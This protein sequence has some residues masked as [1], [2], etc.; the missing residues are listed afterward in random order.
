KEE[1]LQAVLDRVGRGRSFESGRQAFAGAQC[2]L[3]HRM[4]Q[5]GGLF[6]PDLTAASSR[7]NRHDMLDS[8]LNPSRVI[9]DKF[10]N[11]VFTLKDGSSVA[12]TIE[13][14]DEKG[15]V[16]RTNPLVAQTTTLQA[17]DIARREPSTI[18]PMPPGLI[19]VL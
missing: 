18:S 4:G 19:N 17:A 12:G 2:V 1:D 16:I 3:C 6:G 11:I 14:E 7:F 8:I 10:R 9:D 15:V 5:S 13:R